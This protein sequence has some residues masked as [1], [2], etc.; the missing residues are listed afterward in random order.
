MADDTV[1]RAHETVG[2]LRRT[3][4]R[5]AALVPSVA[6]GSLT[7]PSYDS[8]WTIADVL[9]HLGSGAEIFGEILEAGL[10]GRA[11]PGMEAFPVAWER[12]NAK[13][14]AEQAA[15][16]V[17]ANEAFVARMESATDAELAGF[18]VALFGMQVDGAMIARMRLSE[19][20]VHT[21]DV[22]V[23]LEPDARID[24][25]TVALLLDNLPGLVERTSRPDAAPARIHVRTTDPVS[26]HL[27]VTGSGAGLTPWA[28]QA[29]DGTLTL[30]AEAFLRLVYGRLDAEHTPASEITIEGTVDLDA[31]RASFPGF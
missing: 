5:L 24:G 30:P 10:A 31:L 17:V 22:A 18:D 20:A 2:A 6:P 26:E 28:G 11:V 23:T 14:A 9:S 16:A 4:D 21:W 8:E 25:D 3:Q 19:V 1:A 7:A 27:L 15:G 29:V 13:T 12:W